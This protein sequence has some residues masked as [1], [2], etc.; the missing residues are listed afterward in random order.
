MTNVVE[1]PKAMYHLTIL[2]DAPLLLDMSED[3]DEMLG[4]YGLVASTLS[5]FFEGRMSLNEV[6][7]ILDFIPP[8]VIAEIV[9]E[10]IMNG[11]VNISI[12]CQRATRESTL[13]ELDIPA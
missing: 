1:F 4:V 11:K 5:R 6:K 3:S 7:A 8:H 2:E 10:G 9:S 12:M 13:V